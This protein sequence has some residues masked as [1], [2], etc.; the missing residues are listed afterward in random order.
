MA[1]SQIDSRNYYIFPNR[2]LNVQGTLTYTVQT[3]SNAAVPGKD[4]RVTKSTDSRISPNIPQNSRNA[5][6]F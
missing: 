6:P 2:T 4:S 5:P 1:W 3:S